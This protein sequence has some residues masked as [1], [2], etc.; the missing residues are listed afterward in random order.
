MNQ[1]KNLDTPASKTTVVMR[2]LHNRCH[3]G[4]SASLSGVAGCFG[5]DLSVVTPP[6]IKGS[7]TQRALLTE[8]ADIMGKQDGP[9][10]GTGRLSACIM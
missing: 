8:K 3:C 7:A 10:I 9:V 2:G 4:S 1:W 6:S 5:S